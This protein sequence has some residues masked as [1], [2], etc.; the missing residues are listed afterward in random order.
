MSIQIGK[1]IKFDFVQVLC[2][3]KFSNCYAQHISL[4]H[5]QGFCRGKRGFICTGVCSENIRLIVLIRIQTTHWYSTVTTL[6]RE[7]WHWHLREESRWD[8]DR[9]LELN[10]KLAGSRHGNPTEEKIQVPNTDVQKMALCSKSAP[11][12]KQKNTICARKSLTRKHISKKFLSTPPAFRKF[13]T[14]FDIHL[15]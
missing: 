5:A 14:K 6:R 13:L 1:D 11:V 4:V 12:Q 15:R 3:L 9:W 7:W 10:R 2:V 8:K